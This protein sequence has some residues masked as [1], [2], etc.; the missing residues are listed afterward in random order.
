MKIFKFSESVLGSMSVDIRNVAREPAPTTTETRCKPRRTMPKPSTTT[1]KS[2]NTT[3]GPTKKTRSPRKGP[4]ATLPPFRRVF[5]TIVRQ[6]KSGV[7]SPG[8]RLPSE[9]ELKDHFGFSRMT[10]NRAMK[11]LEAVG[12]VERRQGLG[13]FVVDRD[14]P[15]S[16]LVEVGSIVDDIKRRGHEHTAK[17]IQQKK[18]DANKTVMAALRLSRSKK[19]FHSEIVHYEDGTAVQYESRYVS[20]SFAPQY[21]KQDFTKITPYEY[22]FACGDISV[23]Q[24]TMSAVNPNKRIRRLLKLEQNEPCMLLVRRTWSGDAIVTYSEFYY[25]GPRYQLSSTYTVP[26]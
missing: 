14:T 4:H 15:Q 3:G 18:I 26:Y 11:E 20:P 19:V 6:L 25:P 21:L 7:Y 9:H 1:K 24:H 17:V 13:T 10:I 12:L 8:D 23:L 2:A 22:L 5:N 16:P